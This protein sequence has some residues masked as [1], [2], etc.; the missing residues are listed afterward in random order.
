MG[1]LSEEGAVHPLTVQI[2][3]TDPHHNKPFA[4]D[5]GMAWSVL[6]QLR[7]TSAKPNLAAK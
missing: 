6:R 7:D 3:F 5:K 4:D 1:F 2:F